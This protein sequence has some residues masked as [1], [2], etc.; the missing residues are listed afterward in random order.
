[1][2][3]SSLKIYRLLSLLLVLG[4]LFQPYPAMAQ[5]QSSGQAI[6]IVQSGDTLNTIAD[7]FSITTDE[8][9]KANGITDLDS[10]SIGQR[11]KIPGLDGIVVSFGQTFESLSQTYKVT[12]DQLI[13]LNHISSP[14]QLYAGSYL[15][16]P[17]LDENANTNSVVSQTILQEGQS[18]LEAA[19]ENNVN[20]W[21]LALTNNLSGSWE[22]LPG[23]S[24]Y[25]P[26]TPETQ[27]SEIISSL[28]SDVLINPLPIKQG[29]T[30]E[31][32]VTSK[33]PVTLEGILG[34]Y[35]LQFIQEEG[36]HYVALQGIY[37][38]LEPGL[39]PVKLSGTFTNG[40][41]FE[42]QQSILIKDGNFPQDPPLTVPDETIDPAITGPELDQINTI[43]DTFSPTRYWT[44]KFKTPVDEPICINST[45]GDRRSFNGSAYIYFH[46]G[47]DYGVCANLNIYT[48]A[49]GVVVFT[50][51]L[52]VRGNTVIIDHG[53]GVYSGLYHQSE[54]LVKVGDVVS[55]G[56]QI[57]LI[58]S[59]GRVTGPHLHWDLFV[60]GIQ[61]NPLDWLDQTY[62]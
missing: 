47:V 38:V 56:Q 25:Y 52:T 26:S 29:N 42:F 5:N 57:G 39:Y 36:Y 19:V 55:A 46:S 61:V 34:D 53:W 54:I 35:T 50:G 28:I 6:Y 21:V 1:M 27:S 15:F 24:L 48:P 4:L 60:N 49:D 11:L 3:E 33:I 20:P 22:A 8:L 16:V 62:P 18:F 10:I 37:A 41:R 17:E 44:G 7:W 9:A 58:G 30:V 2:I 23:E 43:V 32:S 59:T 14:A 31:V 45:F 51:F 40:S 12:S 13:K